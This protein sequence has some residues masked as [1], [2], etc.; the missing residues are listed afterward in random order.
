[1]YPTSLGAARWRGEKVDLL[2]DVDGAYRT[3]EEEEQP[4]FFVGLFRV[5]TR[6]RA[7]TSRVIPICPESALPTSFLYT[8]CRIEVS[9]DKS[10]PFWTSILL[11]F[12]PDTLCKTT[13]L[14]QD[15]QDS[16]EKRRENQGKTCPDYPGQP[17]SSQDSRKRRDNRD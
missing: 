11:Y 3:A 10:L 6:E 17:L 2:Y 7:G 8:E 13:T 15:S 16:K 1:L 5:R 9:A 12:F 14:S 4:M